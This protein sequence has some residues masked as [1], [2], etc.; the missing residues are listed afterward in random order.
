MWPN[1]AHSR[2]DPGATMTNDEIIQQ[3]LKFEGGYTNDPADA[4]G[5]TNYGITAADYGAFLK[6]GR[7][8]TPAEVQA[9]PQSDAIAIYIAQYLT[10][11]NFIA[12][13]DDKLRMILVDCGVLY[14]TGMAGRWLQAAVGAN[15]DGKVGKD[16]I[17]ALNAAIAAGKVADIRKAVVGARFKRTAEI[18]VNN[19]TQVHFLQGWINRAVG[20]L[21]FV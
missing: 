1:C 13:T 19:P 8:A 11:P 4:G 16:T 20:L 3:V 14:G 5:A 12:V 17:T 9:M 21:A 18:V 2:N 10:A 7:N 6:L 15:P